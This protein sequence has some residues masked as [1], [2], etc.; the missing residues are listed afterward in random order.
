MKQNLIPGILMAVTLAFAACQKNVDTKTANLELTKSESIAIGEPVS[1]TLSG[2][3]TEDSTYWF[4]SPA[5][6]A[7]VRSNGQTATLIFMHPGEYIVRGRNGNLA[8]T[9]TVTVSGNLFEAPAGYAGSTEWKENDRLEIS[10]YRVDSL[11][12]SGL[13]LRF[14]TTEKYDCLNSLLPVSKVE[15][16]TGFR[17][18]VGEV[19]IP[20]GNQCLGG[21]AQAIGFAS[22]YPI[23][24]GTHSFE[25]KLLSQTYTGSIER[26]GN[27]IAITWPSGN[28][29]NISPLIF[30]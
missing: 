17:F 9:S 18:E 1:A 29:I 6:N 21:E 10:A 24:E 27:T 30:D 25:I 22:F 2:A 26:N 5:E 11:A 8:Q 12:G 16:A 14:S 7:L 13:V 23:A 3:P 20:G 19:S 28:D 4:V 15:T